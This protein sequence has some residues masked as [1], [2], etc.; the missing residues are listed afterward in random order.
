M[1]ITPTQLAVTLGLLTALGGFVY[2]VAEFGVP[3]K[4]T[5]L[6]TTRA[7]VKVMSKSL[8]FVNR[9]MAHADGERR[10]LYTQQQVNNQRF[11]SINESIGKIEIGQIRIIE[12][13][14]QRVN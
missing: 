13:L 1:N 8:N 12:L 10:E 3:A 4:S 6:R 11:K 7:R 9:R 5:D 2:K 14:Q